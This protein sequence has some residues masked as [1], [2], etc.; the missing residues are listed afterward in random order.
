[1]PPKKCF[2]SCRK[3]PQADC[4]APQCSYI[5]K[6]RSHYCRLDSKRYILDKV[7]CRP[8]RKK[9]ALNRLEAGPEINRFLRRQL[10]RRLRQRN[11]RSSNSSNSSNRS[12]RRSSPMEVN[13]SRR[14]SSAAKKIGRFFRRTT[15]KRRGRFLNAICNDA[16]VCLAFGTE[17]TKILDFFNH[18]ATFNY[19]AGRVR[20]IGVQSVNGFVNDVTYTKYGYSANAILKSVRHRGADNL[21]YEY[22]VG[23]YINEQSLRFPCFVETY[24]IYRYKSDVEWRH[25][26]DTVEVDPAYLRTA[27]TKINIAGFGANWPLA[28]ARPQHLCILIQHIKD[29]IT[30]KQLVKSETAKDIKIVRHCLACILFQVY[31]PLAVLWDN[32]THYDLHHSNV[33]LYEPVKGKYIQYYYHVHNNLHTLKGPVR[34]IALKSQYIVKMIDYGRSFFRANPR[35]NSLNIYNTVCRTD[36]C[37][38]DCGYNMGLKYL[39]K[40]YSKKFLTPSIP[41]ISSDLRLLNRASLLKTPAMGAALS[42]VLKGHVVYGNGILNEADKKFGTRQNKKETFHSYGEISN[43]MDAYKALLGVVTDDYYG[44]EFEDP[45]FARMQCLGDL[46]V[47]DDGQPMRFEPR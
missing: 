31:M 41:N 36:E 38:P 12:R 19:V 44:S 42:D 15:Q 40:T 47:Y 10:Q 46:H 24:G 8:T 17:S 4:S 9:N 29:A 25:M 20:Q 22:L 13:S 7:T 23:K 32:F 16:G 6:N 27:L 33:L 11:D 18:F 35:D 45:M 21:M 43:I 5:D 2:S 34:T 28:C 26:M 37:L 14:R 39:D 30:F 1:M 3:R